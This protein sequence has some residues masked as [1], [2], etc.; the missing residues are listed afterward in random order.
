MLYLFSGDNVKEKNL[1]YEK[2]I[3]S[4]PPGMETFSVNGN[5]FNPTQIESFYSGSSLFSPIS[6]VLFRDVL[7][8]EEVRDFIL[9]KLN[10][11]SQSDNSF[12]FVEGKLNKSVL[13]AFKKARAEINVF[14]LPKEKKEKFDN[15]LVANAFS[16]KDKLNL[17][18]YFRQAV[19]KGVGME[20][21]IGVLFWKIKDMILK[22]NFSKF[23]EEQLRDFAARLSY[24]LPQARKK[25]VDAESAFEK[26]LLE[27]F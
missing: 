19:D 14:E 17:W 16:Q 1:S 11:M 23:S 20:E 13:D 5:D 25:G 27:A 9:D 18:I 26:F 4:L 2:F 10:P 24:L 12:I 22:G 3:K 7:E 21:L 6:A 15:F 8:R